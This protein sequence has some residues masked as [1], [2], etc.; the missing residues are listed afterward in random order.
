MAKIRS[1]VFYWRSHLQK[2]ER[3]AWTGRPKLTIIPDKTAFLFSVPAALASIG[4]LAGSQ[5]RF[6]EAG[7][8]SLGVPLLEDPELAFQMQ[9][10]AGACLVYLAGY[11]YAYCVISPRT[12]RYA[13][14]DRRALIRT[15]FP[16]PR[17]HAKRLTPGTRIVWDE[18]TPGTILFDEVEHNYGTKPKSALGTEATVKSRAVGFH[19]IND[20]A[21]VH[22]LMQ[23]VAH[24]QAP[25]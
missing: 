24:G 13:L 25:G 22:A 16:W 7:A 20:A 18:N 3:L 23:E 1:D 21:E 6:V 19:R 11:L 5:N 8:S 10:A 17:L 2:G 4:I 9:V 15:S 12:T 14:T